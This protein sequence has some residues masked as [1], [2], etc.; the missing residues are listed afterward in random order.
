MGATPLVDAA[1]VL[2]GSSFDVIS[3][4]FLNGC[5]GVGSRFRNVRG[6]Q[7]QFGG[8]GAAGAVGES[9]NRQE[10]CPCLCNLREELGEIKI[11]SQFEPLG[12]TTSE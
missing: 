3:V 10:R 1:V 12:L 9:M 6:S 2:L 11:R 4:E 5:V 7:V 8:G